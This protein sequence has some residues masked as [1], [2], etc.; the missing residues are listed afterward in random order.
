TSP[1]TQPEGGAPPHRAEAPSTSGARAPVRRS[2]TGGAG[3]L[4]NLAAARG[5]GRG[6]PL[7]GRRPARGPRVPAPL[8]GP[9]LRERTGRISRRGA[10]GGRRRGGG[11]AVVRARVGVAQDRKSTRLNSSHVKIS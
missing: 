4:G 6:A 8:Q 11:A 9:T 7:R 10:R 1:T 2:L 5:R 3:G